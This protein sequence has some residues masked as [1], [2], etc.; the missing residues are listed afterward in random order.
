MRLLLLSDLHLE[1]RSAYD[2]FI[3]PPNGATHLALLGDIGNAKDPG[4][5]EF[6]SRQ[7]LH[8][9]VVFFLLGN[10]EP[11]HSSF[12]ASLAALQKFA[13]ENKMARQSNPALGDFVFM[14]RTRYDVSDSVTVLGCTLFSYVTPEQ[15]DH[16]SFGLNDFYHIEGWSVEQHNEAHVRDVA[17]LN[18]QVERIAKEEPGRKIIIFTHHSPTVDERSLDPRYMY[19]NVSS[20]FST[21]LQEQLSWKNER[22][23]VW[24]FGHTHFN[25]DFVDEGTGKRVVTNQKG[26]CFAQADDFE[27]GKCIEV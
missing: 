10:H 8:F 13:T 16:V 7:L 2:N 24:A 4:L 17:W 1:I 9:E 11:Y 5:F 14:D 3:I 15:R 27:E 21:D 20:G 18:L 22:V 19:S 12:P 23:K 26:Y 6:L 25:C